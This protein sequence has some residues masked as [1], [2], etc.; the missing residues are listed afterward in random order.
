MKIKKL[1]VLIVSIA[2]ML[3]LLASCGALTAAQAISKADA[4]LLENPY[5]LDME[6]KMSCD[7]TKYKKYFTNF[8]IESETYVDGQNCQM[9]LDFGLMNMD[10]TCV[11]NEVYCILSLFGMTSN[12]MKAEL[13]ED[14]FDE[15]MGM[16]GGSTVSAVDFESMS[17]VKDENGNYVI[18][19]TNLNATVLNEYVKEFEIDGASVSLSDITLEAVISEDKYS[20]ITVS[21]DCAYTIGSEK[22]VCEM[23]TCMSFDYEAGKTIIAPT[24]ANTYTVVTDFS[25]LFD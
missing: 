13:G 14:D 1:L 9:V 21:A 18:T 12:K 17:M 20:K 15:L 2:L 5:K 25:K 11:D 4:A 24:D 19:C 23:T 10:I 3:S 16:T 22:V 6:M 8:N 7:D